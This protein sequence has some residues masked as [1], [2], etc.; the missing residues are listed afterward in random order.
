[1]LTGEA[2]LALLAGQMLIQLVPLRKWHK[3]LGLA[4]GRSG[5]EA[6]SLARHVE[7]A[8]TRLPFQTR[9]LCRAVALS[10]ML[11]RR[12]IAHSLIIA[13]RPLGRR[14]GEEDA[15]HAWVESGGKIVLGELA[16]PWIE[17]ARFG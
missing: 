12:G 2:L 9:C 13:S 14:E 7:R 6:H 8:A 17:A 1:M 4:A 3:G 15:L 11:R 5:P 10:L 16:G